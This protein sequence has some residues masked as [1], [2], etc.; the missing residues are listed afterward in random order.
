MKSLTHKQ[1]QERRI[2]VESLVIMAEAY[3]KQS[4]AVCKITPVAVPKWIARA[5]A[6]FPEIFPPS[7]ILQEGP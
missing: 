1:E 5:K 4:I 7:P 6:A 2:C 3:E